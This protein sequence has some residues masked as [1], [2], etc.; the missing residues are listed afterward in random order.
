MALY[1]S[2]S[3]AIYKIITADLGVHR[4]TLLEWVLRDRGRRGCEAG[5][6]ASGGGAVR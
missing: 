3:G 4:A 6:S 2:I 5:R 1:E